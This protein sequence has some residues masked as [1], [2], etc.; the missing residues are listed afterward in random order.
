MLTKSEREIMELLWKTNNSLTATE[1]VSLSPKK[2][3]KTSYIHLLLNSLL[4]KELIKVSGIKQTTKNFART[5]QA[6][7]TREEYLILEIKKQDKVSSHALPFLVSALINETEDT[8]L[9]N[10]LEEM[11]Q[12]RKEKLK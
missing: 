8:E 1:I 7:L 10:E 9:I 3:W 12:K 11:I 4:K 5:F 6:A 2:T